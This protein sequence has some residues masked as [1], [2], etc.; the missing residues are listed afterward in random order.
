[1]INN[2]KRGNTV[3]FTRSELK[4][5]VE[6]LL[7]LYFGQNSD[8]GSIRMTVKDIMAVIDENTER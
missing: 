3:R 4:V 1:M 7:K 5:S 6:N 8:L 2:K